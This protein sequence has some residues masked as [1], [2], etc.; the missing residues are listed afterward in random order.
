MPGL[1][2][3]ERA[4]PFISLLDPES[5]DT[6]RKYIWGSTIL[7]LIPGLGEID[8]ACNAPIRYSVDFQRTNWIRVSSRDVVSS[9]SRCYVLC[10]RECATRGFFCSQSIADHEWQIAIS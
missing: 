6:F 9:G 2:G 1:F 8:V 7:A 5:G 3:N 4:G 10:A